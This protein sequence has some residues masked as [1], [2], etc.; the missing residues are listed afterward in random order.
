MKS[1]PGNIMGM[2]GDISKKHHFEGLYCAFEASKCIK[3]KKGC[4]C[5]N[6]EVYKENELNKQYYCLPNYGENLTGEGSM[7]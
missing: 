4:I 1:M 3:E 2:M 6:C 7:E 5:G